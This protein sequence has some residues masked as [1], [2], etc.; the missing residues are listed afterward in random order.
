VVALITHAP[1]RTRIGEAARATVEKNRGALER[2]LTM[3][4]A[5]LGRGPA[6]LPKGRG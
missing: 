2:V 5:E 3:I 6:A 4:S 1:L